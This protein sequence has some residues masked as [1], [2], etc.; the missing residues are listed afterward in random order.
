MAD[1]QKVTKFQ[2]DPRGVEASSIP[3]RSWPTS[4]FRRTLV[5]LKLVSQTRGR[6]RP[7][8]FRRTLVGLKRRRPAFHEGGQDGF[9]QTL[10]G[11]KLVHERLER[12]LWR[13]QTDPCGVE[14]PPS[15]AT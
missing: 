7:I 15:G 12:G 1:V 8:R 2:T 6:H 14:A 4:C 3:W 13:F 11:L 9:R 10:V 5:G